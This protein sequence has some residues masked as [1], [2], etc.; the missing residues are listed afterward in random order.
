MVKSVEFRINWTNSNQI[1]LC[2]QWRTLF[3]TPRD[4]H[5]NQ[6]G[7]II[8]K[9]IY[10]EIGGTHTGHGYQQAN[11]LA[12]VIGDMYTIW[13]HG[14]GCLRDFLNE[15]NNIHPTTKFTTEWSYRSVSFL[16]VNITSNEEGHLMTD[17]YTKPIDTHQY[18]HCHSCHP[19]YCK[20]TIPYSQALCILQADSHL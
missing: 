7:P 13:P 20:S 2:F 11:C 9:Y 16:N 19:Q 1:S 18:L 5:G 15:I 17:L 14:E 8:C 3:A 4:G 12:E 10:G 6:D